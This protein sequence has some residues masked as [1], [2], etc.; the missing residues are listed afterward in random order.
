[1]SGLDDRILA[2]SSSLDDRILEAST[3]E[4]GTSDFAGALPQR[5]IMPQVGSAGRMSTQT[6]GIGG[7]AVGSA[8]DKLIRPAARFLSGRAE[9]LSADISKIPHWAGPV[10]RPLTEPEQMYSEAPWYKQL[11]YSTLHG[12]GMMPYRAMNFMA[13][14]PQIGLDIIAPE[15]GTPVRGSE[16]LAEEGRGFGQMMGDVIPQV[17]YMS[18]L[19][20]I[21]TDPRTAKRATLDPTAIDRFH[22][23]GGTAP[24]FATGIAMGVP[25]VRG[26]MKPVIPEVRGRYRESNLLPEVRDPLAVEP[27]LISPK[28]APVQKGRQPVQIEAGPRAKVGEPVVEARKAH[29]QKR[30]DIEAAKLPYKEKVKLFQQN[31]KVL[32]TE[33]K[34]LNAGETKP[35]SPVTTVAK[36]T[37]KKPVKDYGDI[38]RETKAE[39]MARK[40]GAF[41]PGKHRRAV[42]Q[43]IANNEVVPLDVMKDYPE[44][45][46]RAKKPV[47]K[48]VTSKVEGKQPWEMTESEFAKTHKP[49]RQFRKFTSEERTNRAA[50]FR[51]GH[52]QKQQVGEYFYTSEHVPDIAFK[53]PKA[54]KEQ[55]HRTSIETALTEGK[56]VPASV[57]KDYPDLVK[58]AVKPTKKVESKPKA[59]QPETAKEPWEMPVDEFLRDKRSRGVSDMPTGQ[60]YK[61]GWSH[62]QT[63]IVHK[64]HES[65]VESAIAEGKPVP[66]SV[67]KDYPD[68]AK[69]AV[70]KPAVGAAAEAPGRAQKAIQGEISRL[71]GFIR[72]NDGHLEKVRAWRSRKKLSDAYYARSLQ[73]LEDR[74]NETGSFEK[75]KGFVSSEATGGPPVDA[76]G[77]P[78]ILGAE[79]LPNGKAKYTLSNGGVI[80]QFGRDLY[81]VYEYKKPG[82]KAL[83]KLAKAKSLREAIKIAGGVGAAGITG[84]AVSQMSEKKQAAAIETGK[85]IGAAGLGLAAF[86]AFAKSPKIKKA[87]EA[88]IKSVGRP[89]MED[90]LDYSEN[91]RVNPFARNLVRSVLGPNQG[92]PG[93]AMRRTGKPK[94]E[95]TGQVQKPITSVPSIRRS[96]IFVERA[97]QDYTKYKDIPSTWTNTMDPT[98]AI[99]GMDGALSLKDKVS[100]GG[101]GPIERNVLWRTRDLIKM[102]SRWL[103][104]METRGKE[105]LKGTKTK[106]LVE[107]TKEVEFPGSSSNPEIARKGQL[108][109]RLYDEIIRNE[110]D[111]RIMRGQKP[112]PYRKGYSPHIIREATIWDRGFGV[113]NKTADVFKKGT[114][115]KPMLPDFVRPNKPFNARELARRA[116]MGEFGREM[117]A[118]KL[119]EGYINT[120]ARDIFNTTIIENNKAMAQQL[121]SMGF[122]K[123]AAFIQD[124]TAE[125]F[126][127][128]TGR[129]DRA[130]MITAGGK[131]APNLRK[132][133]RGFRKSLVLGAFPLNVGWNLAIQTGSAA[134]TV[135]KYGIRNTALGMFDWFTSKEL[136][137]GIRENAYSYII[138]TRGKGRMATQDINR[139]MAASAR[140]NKSALDKVTDVASLL[141][142]VVE[143]NLT[144]FSVAAARRHGRDAGLN[145]QALWEYASEGGSKTQ[146]MYNL[147]DLPGLLRNEVVK[148]TTPFQTFKFEAYNNMKEWAGRA[149]VSPENTRVRTKQLVEF[150]GAVTA[151]NM[152]T[153][154]LANRE[155]WGPDSFIPV[156]YDMLAAPVWAKFTGNRD[157]YVSKRGLPAPTGMMI[158]FATGAHDVIA[159]GKWDRLRK[160]SIRYLPGMMSAPGGTQMNRL[161]DAWIANAQGGVKSGTQVFPI[162]STKEKV[163]SYVYGPWSTTEAQKY[164]KKN[165]K[166]WLQSFGFKEP[167]VMQALGIEHNKFTGALGLTKKGKTTGPRTS[168]KNTMVKSSSRKKNPMLE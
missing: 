154:S 163:R 117:R 71:E 83:R 129:I 112:I 66:A 63:R 132:A 99:Q 144:G 65:I 8:V 130:F 84:A 95:I 81:G 11:G 19:P 103:G 148:T 6:Q 146:S 150:L 120:A 102:R 43:A 168:P 36:A 88:K 13:S 135:P 162:S 127:G 155:P 38:W 161:V 24:I 156:V 35:T 21:V 20:G 142:D 86:V 18:Q 49:V 93:I 58:K 115:D 67:L 113:L 123:S 133:A 97:V 79:T 60:T 22:E 91:I 137:Q 44:F 149:G 9:D 39:Y 85:G 42:H 26:A 1:M 55:A 87:A 166:T 48:P 50:S 159:K 5:D 37:S 75:P 100:L 73:K 53:S 61:A 3:P 74:F 122:N 77:L 160:A 105:I 140:I 96:G 116:G 23:S 51:Q 134:F 28:S 124:W 145:G 94:P 69:K 138:K 41:S 10:D 32:S 52:R 25:G 62:H 82:G 12:P 151:S 109:H 68:L 45:A 131:V 126:A 80:K 164:L 78:Q 40:P 33:I 89:V 64:Q 121:E 92:L 125:S 70:K 57:L 76:G 17:Q 2:V 56:P 90:F 72:E 152:V 46:K 167:T 47:A 7:Q 136:R 141:S 153:N 59:K 31:N 143:N 111:A 15:E 165:E 29:W 16:R 104:E 34:R 108:I 139:G 157:S 147:E 27:D 107:I 14:V 119:L 158:D 54:A 30:Q 4:V 101:S 110:N 128:V 114:E 98:R 106:E 118:N